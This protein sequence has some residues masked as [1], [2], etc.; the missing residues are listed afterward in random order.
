MN[1]TPGPGEE[2]NL[3]GGCGCFT[4]H[5]CRKIMHVEGLT[6]PHIRGSIKTKYLPRRVSCSQPN[7][8][9]L[10]LSSKTEH[11]NVP[12][13]VNKMLEE[14]CDIKNPTKK[15]PRN[16][17]KRKRPIIPHRV[18]PSA[19]SSSGSAGAAVSWTHQ[20]M[21]G[22]AGTLGCLWESARCLG[23]RTLW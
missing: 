21:R 15:I 3:G 10:Q 22:G 1:Q 14:R 17:S 4:T 19:A 16:Q 2:Q 12:K 9:T 7:Q 6:H 11:P 23:G 18:A 20:A 5:S 13:K 8:D